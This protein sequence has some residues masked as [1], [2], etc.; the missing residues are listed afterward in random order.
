MTFSMTF[1]NLRFNWIGSKTLDSILSEVMQ[2]RFSWI[3]LDRQIRSKQ[4]KMK[5]SRGKPIVIFPRCRNFLE[6][7]HTLMLEAWN[8]IMCWNYIE[9]S[10]RL[11]DKLELFTSTFPRI[12]N[13][14][15]CCTSLKNFVSEDQSVVDVIESQFAEICL[16]QVIVS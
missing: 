13:T 14:H 15:Q 4:L 8:P 10:Y 6:L 11:S 9:F 7:G 16:I 1:I 3:R 12:K 2:K 5:N